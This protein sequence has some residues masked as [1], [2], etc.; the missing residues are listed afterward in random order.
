MIAQL[1]IDI[2]MDTWVLHITMITMTPLLSPISLSL[3][4]TGN[5]F[6][7]FYFISSFFC[8]VKKTKKT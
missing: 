7:V 5:L 6:E 3:V 4:R 1:V 8:L 2:M